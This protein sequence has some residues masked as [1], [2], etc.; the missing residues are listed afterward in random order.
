MAVAQNVESKYLRFEILLKP[1]MRKVTNSWHVTNKNSSFV[2]GT[3]KWYSRWRQYC[4]FPVNNTVLNPDCLRVIAE[5]CQHRTIE[6]KTR[7]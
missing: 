5:F 6:H 2:L 1:S 4:F 7:R 3:V